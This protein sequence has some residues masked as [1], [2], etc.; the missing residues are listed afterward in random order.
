MIVL[1][2]SGSSAAL[3]YFTSNSGGS[4]GWFN[5]GD[6]LVVDETSLYSVLQGGGA[7]D[8]GVTATVSKNGESVGS[9]SVYVPPVTTR[10]TN[11][12]G[13]SFW[14][15]GYFEGDIAEVLIYS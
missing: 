3:Q 11:Y 9:G 5:T 4:V 8:A 1:G 15:E 2:R 12:I 7:A 10:S 13:K 14:N 6:A